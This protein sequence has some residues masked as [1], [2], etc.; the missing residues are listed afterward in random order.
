MKLPN[1]FEREVI[2]L[3]VSADEEI[4]GEGEKPIAMYV[5]QSGEVELKVRGK[6]LEVVGPDGF[7]GEM[8]LID[9]GRRSA[10]AVA[11]TDC[12]IIP[13]SEKHFLFMVEETPFFALTVM[14]TMTARLRR[15]DMFKQ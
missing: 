15:M 3:S 5:V 8:A 10:T 11:K 9:Q 6:S 13:V 4:Y 2:P 1:I 14:R 12:T 7:F